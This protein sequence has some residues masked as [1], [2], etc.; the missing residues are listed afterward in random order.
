MALGAATANLLEDNVTS[1]QD[2]TD[3]KTRVSIGLEGRE[4]DLLEQV[5]S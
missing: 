1:L 2:V 4:R 5:M 3:G